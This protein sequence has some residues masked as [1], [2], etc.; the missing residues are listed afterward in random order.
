MTGDL[1][2][3][4]G[5]FAVLGDMTR[6]EFRCLVE[7]WPEPSGDTAADKAAL[8]AIAGNLLRLWGDTPAAPLREIAARHFRSLN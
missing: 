4:A 6:D 5:A 1:A 2:A 8:D 7:N 3:R